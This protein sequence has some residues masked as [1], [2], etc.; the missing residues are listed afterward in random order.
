[1]ESKPSELITVP[2]SRKPARRQ[3]LNGS[4]AR[5]ITSD[6]EAAV[7]RRLWHEQTSNVSASYWKPAAHPRSR[8][9]I[10]NGAD[11]PARCLSDVRTREA[12]TDN[13]R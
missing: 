9:Q 12:A 1:M 8:R 7:V 10:V 5:I 11:S 13:S 6:D 2:R 3:F 4:D